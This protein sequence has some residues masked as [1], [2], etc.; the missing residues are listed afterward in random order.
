MITNATDLSCTMAWY[1]PFERSYSA[2]EMESFTF[3]NK[4]R[5][6]NDMGNADLVGLLP[7]MFSREFKKGEVVFFR[8]DPAAALY[9]I[10]KGTI[11]TSLD[12]EGRL[13]HLT[14]LK[15][16]GYL[17]EEALYAER[18]RLYNAVV[19][20]D[21]AELIVIP[22]PNLFDYCS[23]NRKFKAKLFENLAMAQ[24]DFISK[25][26]KAY[27]QEVGLFELKLAFDSK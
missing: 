27:R 2:Q 3:L 25:L 22:H 21:Q 11:S 24:T 14:S 4:V 10:K 20:S 26:Y 7:Y 15:P 18:K 12:I 17:G 23:R 13:D 5:L 1:N 6:F 8:E 16:Y 19:T 9:L